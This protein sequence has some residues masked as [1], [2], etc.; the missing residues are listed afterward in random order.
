MQKKTFYNTIWINKKSTLSTPT[1][2]LLL[3]NI[4][5][6]IRFIMYAVGIHEHGEISVYTD[7]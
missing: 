7:G 1:L 2:L 5:I 3:C 6:I 4:I